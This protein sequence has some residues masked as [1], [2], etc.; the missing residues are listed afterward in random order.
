MLGEVGEKLFVNHNVMMTIMTRFATCMKLLKLQ[1]LVTFFV[2]GRLFLSWNV[3]IGNLPQH[4]QLKH[5]LQLIYIVSVAFFFFL[6]LV[7]CRNTY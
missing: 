2:Q 1:A 7:I 3:E 6:F 5:E 4:K